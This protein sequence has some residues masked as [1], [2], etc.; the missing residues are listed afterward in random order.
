MGLSSFLQ[1]AKRILRLSVKPGKKEFWLSV[2]FSL[3]AI[4]LIG[5]VAFIIRLVS[6]L[7]AP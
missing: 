6:V 3:L 2:R 5:A 1:S 4:A 7:V